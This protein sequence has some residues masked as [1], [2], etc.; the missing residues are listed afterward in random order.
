METKSSKKKK[1]K[2]RKRGKEIAHQL[3][4]SYSTRTVAWSKQGRASL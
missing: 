1:E 3:A 4:G 2:K